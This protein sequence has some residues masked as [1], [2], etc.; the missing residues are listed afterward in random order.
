MGFRRPVKADV[1]T[2]LKP[3]ILISSGHGMTHSLCQG[4]ER[5][6]M[7]NLEIQIEI[8]LLLRAEYL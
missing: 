7:R 4:Q 2:L 8:W 1:S 6:K 5:H 3:G